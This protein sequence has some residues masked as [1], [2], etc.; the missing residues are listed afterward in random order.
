[1]DSCGKFG[2][3]HDFN[4]ASDGASSATQRFGDWQLSS[5]FQPIFS[6][7]HRRPVG[8]EALLRAHDMLDRPVPLER[9]MQSPCVPA[10]QLQLDRICRRLH[11]T[12]FC[13]QPDKGSWLFVNLNSQSLVTLKPDAGFMNR[14]LSDAGLAARRLVIEILE[15]EIDDRAYLAALIDHFREIGC[16]IAIDDFGSGHSNF[17]RVWE[18]QPDIVK[19]DRSL[20]RRAGQSLKVERILSGIVALIHEAGSLVIIEGV[21][22]EKEALV[23]I[24]S[25]AD[26]VQGFYFGRPA[27]AIIADGR[28]AE[29]MRALLQRQQ[30]VRSQYNRK[31]QQHFEAFRQCFEQAVRR[32]ADGLSFERSGELIFAHARVVRCYLLDEQGYQIGGSLYSPHYS[33]RLDLRYAPLLAGD[34]ANWSHRHYHYR[35]LHQPGRVQISRPYLSV[36]GAHMCLTVSSSVD[37]NGKRHVYCC[38]LDWPDE[39]AHA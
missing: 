9:V 10:M 38:D 37:I 18:L 11:V 6:I 28:F 13:R 1:M 27:P 26:M 12:N 17:D 35:A 36:A 30:N 25:N 32:V 23:A 14:L 5:V 39:D 4:P 22:T 31:L 15:S 24:A 29:Q 20:I 16:L 3:E 21:E 2:V 19:I 33:N 8:Y 7:A 34:N